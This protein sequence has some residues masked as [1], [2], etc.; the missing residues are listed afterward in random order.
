MTEAPPAG[1]PGDDTDD[2]LILHKSRT[3]SG[4]RYL[5]GKPYHWGTNGVGHLTMLPGPDPRELLR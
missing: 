1:P 4:T 3:E 5:A 2:T